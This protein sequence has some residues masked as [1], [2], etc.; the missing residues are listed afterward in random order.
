MKYYDY[1][2]VIHFHSE[3]S[4]DGHVGLDKIIDAAAK[5]GIDFLMLTDHN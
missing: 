5:N 2:G 4:F 1:T 3:Y